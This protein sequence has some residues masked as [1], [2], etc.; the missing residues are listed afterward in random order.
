[1]FFNKIVVLPKLVTFDVTKYVTCAKFNLSSL[2]FNSKT[3]EK[4]K[5]NS[6]GFSLIELLLVVTIIGILAA[7]AVPNLLR[8]RAAGKVAS[9]IANLKVMQSEQMSFYN[10]KKRFA[11]VSELAAANQSLGR[12]S[13]TDVIKFGFQFQS[14]P[15]NPNSLSNS[16]LIQ[17]VQIEDVKGAP[18]TF[19]LN[20][21][22][23]ITGFNP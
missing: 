21:V 8:S 16:Y 1:M 4:M 13:G 19:S 2:K 7:I 5:K 18:L 10:A 14:A 15:N 12:V 3:E 11:N 20:S 22:G 9:A 17:A 6:C 23:V